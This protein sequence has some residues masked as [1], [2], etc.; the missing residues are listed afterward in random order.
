MKKARELLLDNV[1]W[2]GYGMGWYQT[3]SDSSC[4]FHSVAATFFFSLRET[5]RARAIL[6]FI[7][8]WK[9]IPELLFAYGVDILFL[10]KSLIA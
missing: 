2:P 5:E 3:S 1:L 4:V 10:L 6:R 8:F 9:G 7:Q